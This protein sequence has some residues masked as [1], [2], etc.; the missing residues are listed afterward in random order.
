MPDVHEIEI[1]VRYQET[2][3]QRRVHH[4][5][6]LTYFEMGRTE[7][8]RAHGHSY[9]AFEDAGLF[10]VVSEA[11][12]R[13]LAPAEYDD[14]LRLRTRVE[15]IGAAHIRHAYEVI[16]GTSILV[17]GTTTV[18]CV[19]REGRVRRLPDWMLG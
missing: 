8:L 19:D 16:R 3:G 1:R 9:R 14:L 2:D 7:M 5:N 15:K 17:T 4:A 11:T 10:M 6:F 12:V 13:Y 18:V